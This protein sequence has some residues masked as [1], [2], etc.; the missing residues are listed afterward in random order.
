[1][2]PP[3]KGQEEKY[4]KAVGAPHSADIPYAL[5]NLSLDKYY[6]FTPDDFKASATMEAYFANFVKTGNPNGPGLPK[7][8][9]LQSSMPRVM[10]L[11]S[12]SKQAP[13]KNQWR[14][15]FMNQ[16]YYK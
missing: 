3:V 16:L 15:Q 10:L 4:V 13:E 2:L 9:G 8:S 1:L 11:N 14:Y 6:A 12:D 5:G 7:W